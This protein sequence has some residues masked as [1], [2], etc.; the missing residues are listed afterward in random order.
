MTGEVRS[1]DAGLVS[2]AARSG[3]GFA[4]FCIVTKWYGGK[5]QAVPWPIISDHAHEMVRH[6]YALAALIEDCGISIQPIWT[7]DPGQILYRDLWQVVAK[8]ERSMVG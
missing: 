3:A 4:G 1:K 7:R 8:P 5:G 6:A 2:E